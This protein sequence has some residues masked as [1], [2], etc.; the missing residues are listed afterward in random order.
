MQDDTSGTLESSTTSLRRGSDSSYMSSIN[1]DGS[2]LSRRGSLSKK[3]RVKKLGHQLKILSKRAIGRST[4][5]LDSMEYADADDKH[6]AESMLDSSVMEHSKDFQREHKTMGEVVQDKLG[7]VKHAAQVVLHPRHGPQEKAAGIIPVTE[8]P[9][10]D[11]EADLELIQAEK[12]LKNATVA[13]FSKD[14]AAWEER[15]EK[16][17]RFDKLQHERQARQ[18]AW[19][20]GKHVDRVRTVPLRLI[21][22]PIA[23]DFNEYDSDGDHVRWQWERYFG[24]V[25]V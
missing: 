22:Y 10:V 3:G 21:D 23:G 5:S 25:S 18:D 12:E 15:E 4:E 2:S 14:E 6:N 17:E 24:H 19:M 20:L 8:H 1:E 16:Q 13:P 9:Y 7:L 11:E